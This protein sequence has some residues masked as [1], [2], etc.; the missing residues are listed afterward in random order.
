MITALGVGVRDEDGAWL[1]RRVC[2]R[3]GA[4]ELTALIADR[5]AEAR[6]LLECIAGHRVAAEGRVW[7]GDLPVMRETMRR[8]RGLVGDVAV[9]APPPNR[10]LLRHVLLTPGA[11]LGRLLP[12]PHPRERAAALQALAD[13]GLGARAR[14]SASALSAVDRVRLDVA[15]GF[16][17]QPRGLVVRDVE[18]TLPATVAGEILALIRK[19]ARTRRVPVIASLA[20]VAT[21]RA[22]ADHVILLAEGRVVF[23]G[24]PDALNEAHVACGAAY[25]A[26]GFA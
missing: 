24:L 12:L 25:A 5:P 14:E 17:H 22:Y 3:P 15:R 26:P 2:L 7:I 8:V 18:T 4:G 11:G 23:D 9:G 10:S 6:A 19:L 21:A 13:V 16:A 1:L 20:S